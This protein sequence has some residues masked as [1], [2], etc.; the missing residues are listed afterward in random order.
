MNNDNKFLKLKFFQD[1]E[2]DVHIVL[3]SGFFRNGKIL[4]LN[5]EKEF[6]ILDEDELGETPI[7]L[8]E[9]SDRDNAIVKRKREGGE[10]DR[11]NI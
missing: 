7:M 6:V 4:D 2:I 5:K 1:N 8:E 9:I 11:K 10:D 3:I